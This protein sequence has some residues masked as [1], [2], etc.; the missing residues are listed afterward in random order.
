MMS[1][2]MAEVMGDLKNFYDG[3]PDVMIG[4]VLG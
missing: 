1:P 2:R 3:M 4:E